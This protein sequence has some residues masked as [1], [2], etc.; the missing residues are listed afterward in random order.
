MSPRS[1][2]YWCASLPIFKKWCRT[3][4]QV[5]PSLAA[6]D[7]AMQTDRVLHPGSRRWDMP[8]TL[9]IGPWSVRALRE[10]QRFTSHFQRAVARVLLR[11]QHAAK[12]GCWLPS[13]GHWGQSPNSPS[14][15]RRLAQRLRRKA[16]QRRLGVLPNW[17]LTPITGGGSE[18]ETT[19]PPSPTPP[20]R[21]SPVPDSING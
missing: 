15:S 10:L 12:C 19:V 1:N 11:F 5:C 17:C 14:R 21:S 2:G 18:G 3:S 4:N 6:L 20:R 13:S 8:V 9:Q 7:C 16:P